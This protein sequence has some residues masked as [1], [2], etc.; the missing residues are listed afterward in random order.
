MKALR[1]RIVGGSLAGLFAGILLGRDGHDVKIYERSSTGFAGRGAGLVPQQEVFHILRE[2]GVEHLATFGVVS[3]HRIYLTKSGTV[4]QRMHTPQMQISWD[5]LYSAVVSKLGNEKYVLGKPVQ[6]VREENG[7]SLIEFDDGTSEAADLVIGADGIGSLVRSAI[8]VDINSRYAGYVAWR[9]LVPENTLPSSAS[10]LPGN[11]AFYIAPGN[12]ALGYLVPGADG[13]IDNG[14]RRYNWVWYRFVDEADL[15]RTFTGISG[16][17][18]RFSLARGELSEVRRSQLR[19]DAARLLPPQFAVAINAEETPSVQGIFDYEAERMSG[20][21]TA[22][23]GDAAFVVRPHTAMG[24]AKAAGDVMSLRTHLRKGANVEHAL[25]GF[26][27]E[28][29]VVGHE[30]AAYGQ[31][32]GRSSMR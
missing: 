7:F 26:N 1:I 32:L 2:I 31:E 16:R 19:E 27:A 15:E 5:R 24:V 28:R 21:S 4:S 14:G 25:R 6:T 23:I 10:P 12:H 11:F 3:N 29:I 20:R 18:S 9:G 8:N 13:E 17:S 30:I 22:L